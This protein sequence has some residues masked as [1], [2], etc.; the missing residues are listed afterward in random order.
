MY[1]IISSTKYP[2]FDLC[3]F[4]SDQYRHYLNVVAR[5]KKSNE[6]CRKYGKFISLQ[7]WG[8]LN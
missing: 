4:L 6:Q 8:I 1:N 2:R 3:Q 7:M 5:K